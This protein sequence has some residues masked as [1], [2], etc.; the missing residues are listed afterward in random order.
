M[1]RNTLT[2]E[3][4]R[5]LFDYRD[6]QLFWKIRRRKVVMGSA[7]GWHNDSGYLMVGVDAIKFRVHRLIF[8]WHHGHMPDEI[9]HIDRDRTNNHIEN[10]RAVS[11]SQNN[12]NNG[13]RGT[14][15]ISSSGKWRAQIT[16]RGK[17]LHV[18]C[19]DTEE[20]AHAAYLVEKLKR[21]QE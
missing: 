11:H 15:F 12:A 13:S 17:G 16:I 2:Q 6:G 8:L 7:A 5:S 18:G 4:V 3:Y 14:T 20:A 10:L 1:A 19:F 21:Q 9:D